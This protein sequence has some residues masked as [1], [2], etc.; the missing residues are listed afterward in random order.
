[1]TTE[2]RSTIDADVE[3]YLHLADQIAQLTEQQR[4]VKAR[5]ATL[6]VGEHAAAAAKVVVREPNRTFDVTQAWQYLTPEQQAVAISPDPKKVKAQLPQVLVDACMQ[7][8]KGD[9]IV[10]VK[11]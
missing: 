9:P 4:Q 6:G 2:Q 7:P 11:P 5:L 3:L 1:M 8:G 10:S